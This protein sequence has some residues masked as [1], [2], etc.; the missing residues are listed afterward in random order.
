M[1]RK[2]LLIIG[3]LVIVGG[4]ALFFWRKN[5]PTTTGGEG[6]FSFR[7]FL[8]FGNS[9][10]SSNDN[11]GGE[12][13]NG[14][15]GDENGN[16]PGS[17]TPFQTNSPLTKL[18][19]ISEGPVAGAVMLNSGSTTIVRFIEK[20]TGNIYEARSDSAV[21]KR[22][23][24]TTIPKVIR[25][26][27]LPAGDSLLAQTVSEDDLIETSY[28]KLKPF[29]ATST[30]VSAPFEVA[31]SKL[32]TGIQEISVRPDGKKIVYYTKNKG[33]DWYIS[34]PDGTEKSVIYRSPIQGWIPQWY[35]Q[36]SILITTKASFLAPSYGYVLN[37]TSGQL[38][39]V[40]G[41]Q[42]GGSAKMSPGGK[43]AI[44]STGGSDPILNSINITNGS[45]LSIGSYTLSEKCAW[46]P[47]NTDYVVCGIPQSKSTGQYPDDWYKGK[48]S[49]N[50]L[51]ERINV[52]DNV[53][54]IASN[55]FKDIN[56]E[57]DVKEMYVS[58]NSAYAAFVNKLDSAL[59]LLKIKD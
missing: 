15:N 13:N 41:S 31:I 57:I 56:E 3:I 44:V 17:G 47:S 58:K 19:R 51:I 40:F 43:F 39:T 55:P 7:N 34:N 21:V 35:S 36:N 11:A 23:T 48:A 52:N 37:V 29:K 53:V 33:S 6:G 32:P 25:A 45:K 18:R 22:L 50:D 14:N 24:N 54:F 16:D 46:D 4:V 8:P 5:S 30:E 20:A 28:L 38:S 10:E 12:N 27:W 9:E 1:T 2:I 26:F 59:W 49:T 42:M